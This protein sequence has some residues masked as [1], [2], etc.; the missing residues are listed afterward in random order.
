MAARQARQRSAP[1]GA[2]APLGHLVHLPAP[3]F[4]EVF[5][6]QGEQTVMVLVPER[7]LKYPA[8]HGKQDE[9]QGKR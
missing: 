9:F 4:E 3:E 7:V 1:A 6:G 8:G 5:S 2:V